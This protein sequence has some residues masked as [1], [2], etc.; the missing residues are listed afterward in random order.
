MQSILAKDS[1]GYSD[2]AYDDNDFEE[3][4]KDDDAKLENLRKALARENQ[5]AVKVVTKANI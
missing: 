4:N 2:E 1:D 3:E 5:K